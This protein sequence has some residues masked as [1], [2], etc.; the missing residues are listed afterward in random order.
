MSSGTSAELSVIPWAILGLV[1]YLDFGTPLTF[2]SHW[3]WDP[4][5]LSEMGQTPFKLR[6]ELIF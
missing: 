2:G 6:S 3:L 4:T 1:L 5:R